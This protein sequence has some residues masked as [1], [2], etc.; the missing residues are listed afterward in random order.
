[1][2]EFFALYSLLM[3]ARNILASLLLLFAS[4][5][6]YNAALVLSP[7]GVSYQMS[8][9]SVLLSP[10]RVVPVLYYTASSG[11]YLVVAGVVRY[12]WPNWTGASDL[13][14]IALFLTLMDLNPYCRSTVTKLLSVTSE[15]GLV[16]M[17]LPYLRNRALFSFVNRKNELRGEIELIGY[18]SYAIAWS[19][20][21]VYVIGSLVIRN[22]SL[23]SQQIHVGQT[24]SRISAFLILV[25]MVGVLLY[26]SV[27]LTATVIRNMVYPVFNQV[28]ALVGKALSSD[29]TQVTGVGAA[30]IL[31]ETPLFQGISPQVLDF[32]V[33]QA[34]VKTF[35]KGAPLIIQ[36]THNSTLFV[37][38]EGTVSVRKRDGSGS[39]QYVCSLS[40]GA[41]IGETSVLHDHLTTADVTAEKPV[42][43]L[44]ISRA[45]LKG[46][47]QVKGGEI[48]L[49]KL[50][51][52]IMVGQYVSSSPLFRE[53]PREV[54]HLIAS[55]G[56]MLAT[57][58]GETITVQGEHDKSF[59][60]LV[61]GMV[62][63]YVDSIKVGEIKQGGFFGEIALIA[64]VPR[65]ATVRAA[66]VGV[67][68]R[69]DSQVF[70]SLLAENMNLSLFIESVAE[71]R[72]NDIAKLRSPAQDELKKTA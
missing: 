25:G 28:F 41:I 45:N 2:V 11:L 57:V 39:S 4:G 63:V 29:P 18:S 8:D 21:V 50:S 3:T 68:L 49:E 44:L 31:S 23:L 27:D 16:G 20:G 36:G 42:K 64:D 54:I 14:A 40:S 13:Q 24:D 38:L 5:T 35:R 17:F 12:F 7:F 69:I 61:R 65:T 56:E 62:E 71:K 70:W 67:V 15:E 52:R 46:L 33:A 34:T 55:R 53:V 1:L 43:A 51:L 59:Y 58:P 66:D 32:L 9:S 26:F 37:L 19:I 48:E 6:V 22:F 10:T 60:L 30:K 72:A 47:T